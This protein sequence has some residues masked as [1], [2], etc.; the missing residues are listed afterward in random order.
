VVGKRKE[1]Y[2]VKSL[3][4]VG[5]WFRHVPLFYFRNFAAVQRVGTGIRGVIHPVDSRRRVR[6]IFCLFSTELSILLSR[7]AISV[8]IEWIARCHYDFILHLQTMRAHAALQSRHGFSHVSS[9]RAH[10]ATSL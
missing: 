1:K 10:L 4:L 8:I 6:G 5:D 9:V 7:L 2:K 3:S